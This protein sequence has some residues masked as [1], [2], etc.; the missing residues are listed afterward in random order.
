MASNGTGSTKTV[1]VDLKLMPGDVV[2]TIQDLQGKIANLKT[3]MQGMKA[4]G[5]ENTEQYIKLQ[6]VMKDMQNTL[7]ANQKVLVA[8]IQQQKSNGDSINALRGQLKSLRAEYEDLSKAERE[9]AK[10]TDMLNHIHDLTQELKGMEEAQLDFSRNVGNYKSALEGFP[11][12]KVIAGFNTLSQGTGKLS[13]AFANAGKAAASFSKQMLKLLTNPFVAAIAAIVA[14]LSKLV[15]EIKKNDEAMTAMQRVMA[16]FKPILDIINKA[17]A[18]LVD[19]V[20]K[21]AN[22]VAGF[23]TK[24]MSVIPGVKDY[25]TAEQ[26]LVNATDALEETEREHTINSA[27]REKEISE[28]RN[29]S[30]QSNKYSFEQRK[31]YLEQAL[32]LEQ[33]ELEE[34]KNI[35]AEK[36]RIAQEEA[37]LEVGATKMTEEVYAKL[38]DEVKNHLAELEAAVYQTE[39][40]FNDGTRRMQSQI[41]NFTKQEENERKQAAQKA[42]Q[43]RKERMKNEREALKALEDMYIKGIKNLQDQEIAQTR[44]TYGQQIAAIREKLETEKNLTKKARE[45][46]NQQMVLLEADLQL[47]ISEIRE[48]N[49]RE[50]YD[51]ALQANKDYYQ[52]ILNNLTEEDARVEIKLQINEIDTEATVRALRAEVDQIQKIAD[53][54]QADFEG[55]DYN[56]LVAKYSAVWEA[57]GIVEG[58]AIAKMRELTNQYNQE[59]LEAQTRLENNI[60]AVKKAG[61]N[62]ALRIQKE[63]QDKQYSLAQKHAE[64]MAA[65]SSTQELDAYRYNEQEKTRILQEQAE[66]RLEIAR[67]EQQR[68]AQERQQYTDEQLA[69]MYGSVEEFNNKFAE[70]E[71]KIVNAEVAV[72]DAIAEVAKANAAAKGRMIDTATAVMGAMNDVVGSIGDLFNTLADSDEKYEGF[73]LAMAE[74]QILISTAISIAQAIQGAV[75]AG[76]ATGVAAPL[77]TPVFI[78]EM[79]AIVVGAITSAT[80]TLLKAK[81]KKESAPKFATGGEIKHGQSGVD[82]VPIMATKGEYVIKKEV[83]DD[84]GVEFFDYINFGKKGKKLPKMFDGFHFASGGIIQAPNLQVSQI[85]AQAFDFEAMKTAMRES[86]GEA[87]QEMPNP[88]VSVK[89]ITNTQNRVR[90]KER[91]SRT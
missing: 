40:A 33:Q 79:V 77:T 31:K 26:D 64:I 49:E 15:N 43:T 9:S 84:L 10:G 8:E 83:V 39:T 71:L 13:V 20:A 38:S 36:Y 90:T 17:F 52:R 3:T 54:A 4:A 89:E 91:I 1:V 63:S 16:A 47:K 42:A 46:Y 70:S 25:V 55:L 87:L 81:N 35:A 32:Q 6:G 68:L 85:A 53:A 34:S 19:V 18:V 58:D 27:K 37:L 76:A 61:E 22:A 30:V 56:E 78:A 66:R 82:K 75:T 59:A 29:K 24:I 23:V 88:V 7:R 45:A 69:A 80:T 48:K 65:I 44:A 51:K 60:N 21:A 86:M 73:A 62:E 50:R 2:K 12:G 28:L 5:L 41:S 14:V 11:F 57:R 72:K 67:E 74:M